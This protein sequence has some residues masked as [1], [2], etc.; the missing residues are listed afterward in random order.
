MCWLIVWAE[1]SGGTILR[2]YLVG[3]RTA[4]TLN[5][6]YSHVSTDRLTA[7]GWR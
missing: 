6:R 7:N 5:F 3:T 2:G 4:D 1:Y